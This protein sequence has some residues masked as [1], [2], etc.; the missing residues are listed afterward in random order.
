MSLSFIIAFFHNI[1][2]INTYSRSLQQI[3]FLILTQTASTDFKSWVV[4]TNLNY[5]FFR[6]AKVYIF[7]TN[8]LIHLLEYFFAS[9]FFFTCIFRSVC[10]S[11]VK[12]RLSNKYGYETMKREENQLGLIR[13]PNLPLP[14]P[15]GDMQ[16][17]WIPKVPSLEY[18]DWSVLITSLLLEN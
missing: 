4:S 11:L 5:W 3:N 9:F 6:T 13:N 15:Q 2:S 7:W 18:F 1:H 17:N 8:S 12:Y 14:I 10:F 16:S